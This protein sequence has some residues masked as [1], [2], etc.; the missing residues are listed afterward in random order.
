MIK[1]SKFSYIVMAALT[2]A[3][4]G[5]DGTDDGA[6]PAGGANCTPDTYVS[7]AQ[8]LFMTNCTICHS[9]A[10]AATLGNNVKLDTLPDIKTHKPHIIEHAVDLQAPIMPS[11]TQGLPAA[12]R[13]RLKKWLNCGAP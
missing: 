13:E 10:Q 11:G 1:G 2:F 7:F 12:D 5:D 8:P 3:A 4:C 9:A 6:T